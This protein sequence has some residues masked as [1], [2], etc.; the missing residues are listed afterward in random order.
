ME[1]P[2][3]SRNFFI[4]AVASFIMA[5]VFYVELQAAESG[6]SAALAG[7]IL[8]SLALHQ[9]RRLRNAIFTLWIIAAFTLGLMFPQF[10]LTTGDFDNRQLI[11][12]LL[13]FIMFGMGCTISIKDF[14][15]VVAMPK[16]VLIGVV[17][18]FTLMPFIG[19]T[20][21]WLSGLPAEI[22]A[23]IILVGCSPS[24]LASNVMCYIAR[25]N[26]A[27]SLTLTAVATLIAPLLTPALMKL[28]A[29]ELVQIDALAMFLNML[30]IVI[31]P[32]VGGLLVSHFLQ[33]KMTL[34]QKV[35]PLFSMAGIVIII[36]IIAAAGQI[37][38]LNIGL[39]LIIVVVLHNLSGFGLGYGLARLFRLGEQDAR[40]VAFEV[41]MQNSG[42]A[43]G[44]ALSMNKLATMGLAPAFFSPAM[45]ISGS[46]LATWWR[47]KAPVEQQ[48]E[49]AKPHSPD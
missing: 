7:F 40:T 28:L 45:N 14:A 13:M 44:I 25:A 38:I 19:V 26:V 18:Q 39:I 21:A 10:L 6:F 30:K 31:L 42:L 2:A 41:G 46:A 47:S 33:Q 48:A 37:A 12:P 36:A 17:C 34:I 49:K 43:S 5:A 9:T 23:G 11:I 3:L 24:G 32:V 22:A 20:L 29:G 27:L 15:R 8:I 4:A 35:M 16:A 1:I